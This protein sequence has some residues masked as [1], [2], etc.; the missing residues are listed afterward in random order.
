[1]S[2]VRR[3]LLAV[4]AASI[5]ALVPAIAASAHP[6]G[7][8][9]VNA[10][11]DVVV[12]PDRVEATYV[13]DLAELPTVQAR[14]QFGAAGGADGWATKRCASLATGV[15]IAGRAPAVGGAPLLAF[16]PGQGGLDTLRLECALH[17]DGALAAGGA[18]DVVDS[19][20]TDRIG[21]REIVVRGDGVAITAS[22]VPSVSPSALLTAYPTGGTP[23]R[24]MRA[25]AT[26]KPGALTNATTTAAART[27]AGRPQARGADGLTRRMNSLVAGR[28]LTAPLAALAIALAIVLG[29]LHSLAP[30][31]GKTLM[32][33]SVVA[34]RGGAA[35]QVVTIGATVAAT[36]TTGVL[37]LGIAIWTSQAVAPD[38]VLPWLA[39]AS[40]GLLVVTGTT[41]AVRRLRNGPG[42]HHH[43]PLG[44]AHTTHDHHDTH[45]HDHPH[46]HPH[47]QAGLD[48][49]RPHDDHDLPHPHPHDRA[50]HEHDHAHEHG[51]AM[52]DHESAMPLSRRWLVAMG[53]AGGMVPTPSAL[54]VLLGAAALGRTWFGVVLVAVYGIGM[55]AT[56]VAAGVALVRL[57][58]WLE[59]HWY[60]T[61]W[62]SLTLRL[63]PLATAA[64]LVVGGT[65]LAVR[66][67]PG[68]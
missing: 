2:P 16:P 1:M 47:D 35:R 67:L 58:G 10:A 36:H 45:D 6:L 51:H 52:H 13:L 56:L 46:P 28:H 50:G 49:D 23:L 53:F 59:R 41:L 62:L 5:G 30:G 63:A 11:V 40:G 32:A 48:H 18:V 65:T 33:A 34:R 37:V 43:G 54:V 31:H 38:R 15:T 25:H 12:R 60:G 39:V 29:G 44:H 61:R 64:A 21:W 17:L 42:H 66:S 4:A 20:D 26:A 19:N 8:L 22:D 68:V 14:Q 55:A 57:Q 27:T 9:T 24:T 7:N 3:W